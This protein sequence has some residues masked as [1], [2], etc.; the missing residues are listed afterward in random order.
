MDCFLADFGLAKSVA[1]G[2]KLTRTGQALG[3]PAYMSPEQ[4]RGEVAALAPATDVWSLGCVLFEILATRPPF[5]GETPAGLIAGVLTQDPPDLSLLRPDVPAGLVRVV[6]ACL[7]KGS[8]RR[9]P[10]ARALREDLDRVLRGERPR[11]RL[12]RR[13][14]IPLSIA[15]ALLAEAAWGLSLALPPAGGRAPAA[16]PTPGESP[17]EPLAARARRVRERD[18]AEAARLLGEALRLEPGRAEW[19]LEMGLLLWALGRGDAAAEEWERVPP[20]H[21]LARAARLYIGLESLF[22]S[23]EWQL[24]RP[25][26]IEHFEK[27]RD[28]SG[29]EATLARGAIAVL[30]KKWSSARAVLAALPGWE[31]A[32]LRGFAEGKDPSGNPSVAVREFTQALE[33][34]IPFAWMRVLRAESRGKLGDAPGELQDLDEAVR[35]A[36]DRPEIRVNRAAARRR[37][38]D[39]GGAVEDLDEAIRLRP[40]YATAR[41]NRAGL[42]RA[43]QDLRGALEDLDGALRARPD[44]AD[45]LG[46]RGNVHLDLGDPEAAVRDYTASLELRPGHVETIYHRGNA[47]RALGDPDRAIA[48]YTAAI[49]REPRHAWAWNNRALARRE[50]GDLEGARGDYDTILRIWPER[51]QGWNN[52]GV[53]RWNLGDLDGAVEDFTQALRLEPRD[54][55]TLGNLGRVRAEQ[56]RWGEAARVLAEFLEVSP[57]HPEGPEIRALREECLARAGQSRAA[58]GR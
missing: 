38:G 12:P 53:V 39:A 28:G 11:A 13:P 45:A 36:P 57:A 14:W 42:R 35:I 43:S 41:N 17:G 27:V 19:R 24:G 55:D 10:D 54:G 51:T 33:G 44:Y 2:S 8:S 9:P 25:H 20:D 16:A 7:Q 5:E 30:E 15:G 23:D 49:E 47:W 18:A 50:R 29:P 48:D 6:A 3:T 21:E 56:G 46:N 34:P 1:T 58:G 4:A 37:R 32:L 40:D 52:R 22:H 26:T 31:A